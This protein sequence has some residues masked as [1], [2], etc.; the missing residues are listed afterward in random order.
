M[1][2]VDDQ[3]IDEW[4]PKRLGQ[5]DSGLPRSKMSPAL[6][7]GRHRGPYPFDSRHAAV[8]IAIYKAENGCW[9]IPLT[10]RP[11]SLKHHGGQICLPGGRLEPGESPKEA[12]L[13][14][15]EEELGVRP[16]QVVDCGELDTQYV[17]NS[18]NRVHPVV[19]MIDAPERPWRP[20][21]VEVDEVIPL[22]LSSFA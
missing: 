11:R 9:T 16:Q 13:R 6:S 22:L 14:E 17:Y 8:L 18:N 20:D 4:L 10:R 12:A 21:P 7:Y 15:F 2:V 3:P 1:M 5:R 19:A